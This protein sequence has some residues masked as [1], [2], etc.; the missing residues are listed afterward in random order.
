MDRPALTP[1]GMPFSMRWPLGRIGTAFTHVDRRST[2]G[3]ER[4][5]SITKDRGVVPRDTITDAPPRAA[6]L[7]GYKTCATGDLVVNQMSVYDGLLGIAPI[8][9]LVTYHYLVFRPSASVDARFI[10]YVLR[11]PLY[12]SDFAQRVRGLGDSGQGNVRT[13]HI[14]IGDFLQ[15][16]VPLPPL[17]VQRRIADFLDDQVERLDAAVALRRESLRLADLRRTGHL[18]GLIEELGERNGWGRFRRW[19]RRIEQGWSPQCSSSA[20]LPGEPGVIKLSAVRA[21]QFLAHENKAFLEGVLPDP[22]YSLKHHDLLVTR[23][24]TPVLVGDT[25]V[26]P[27]DFPDLYLSDLVYRV[28]IRDLNPY[29]ASASLRSR[30]VRSVMAATGRGASQTM[31]KIR[32]DDIKDVVIPLASVQQ[33]RAAVA[34]INESEDGYCEFARLV[35]TQ[36]ALLEERKHSLITAA[37]TGQFDVSAAS[38]RA[39]GVA[40]SGAGGVS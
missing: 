36:L 10:S 2:T 12:T 26:V 7:I 19:I 39:A 31:A 37:V 40:L 28:D 11:M 24:N 38:S 29:F 20:A 21:G 5:L 14:R 35:Q 4:L 9:G 32:G 8:D 22:R 33:Q 25:A 16:I 27:S 3:A 6:T 13:P 15:T 1:Q 17:D 30:R 23:A 34:S 18:D